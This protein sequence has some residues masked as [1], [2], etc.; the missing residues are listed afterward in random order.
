MFTRLVEL[1]SKRGKA[2]ELSSTI[3][4]KI[5][6]ILKKQPGFVDA[7]KKNNRGLWML[8]NRPAGGLVVVAVDPSDIG[9][10]HCWFLP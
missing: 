8:Q 3:N 1:V 2:R 7:S 6:P 5:V 9:M 4:D 10:L